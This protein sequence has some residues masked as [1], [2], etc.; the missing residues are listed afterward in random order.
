MRKIGIALVLLAIVVSVAQGFG[1]EDLNGH[2]W[3]TFT[4]SEKVGFVAGYLTGLSA[5]H[6]RMEL[7]IEDQTGLPVTVETQRG[8]QAIFYTPMS[9]DQ[10][11]RGLDYFYL[12]RANRGIRIGPVLDYV[13]GFF[14]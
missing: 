4:Q 12:E 8:L 11:V 5:A 1:V 14:D 13:A 10:L 9:V 7:Q 2:D 3:R 6:V